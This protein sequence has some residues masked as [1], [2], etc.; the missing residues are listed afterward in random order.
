MRNGSE[1]LILIKNQ[2]LTI[3]DS[4]IAMFCVLSFSFQYIYNFCPVNPHS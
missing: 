3:L 1:T 4:D 2:F